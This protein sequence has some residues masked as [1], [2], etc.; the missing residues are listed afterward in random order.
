VR[1]SLARRCVRSA[2]LAAALTACGHRA[3]PFV[4]RAR[5]LS[6]AVFLVAAWGSDSL[7]LARAAEAALDSAGRAELLML[8]TSDGSGIARVNRAGGQGAQPVAPA[9]AELLVRALDLARASGG[10]FDPT[11]RDFRGLSVDTAH[12][13]VTLRRGLRLDLGAL[14]RGYALDRALLALRGA[15]DSAVLG[16]GGLYLIMTARSAERAGG[17]V[18]G[19]VDPDNTLRPLARLTVQPGIWSVSTMS[20][21][22]A[23]DA[24]LDPRTGSPAARARVVAAVA[25]SAAMAGG[26]SS[27]F[28][29]MGCDSALALAPRVGASVLCAD[30]QLRWSADLNGRVA[31][32]TDSAGSVGTAPAHGRGHAPAATAGRNGSTS[33]PPPRSS[34]SRPPTS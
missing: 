32:A 3:P 4:A 28:Y 5:E 1:G 22:E 21:A 12:H 18:V 19:I 13:T 33:L 27:A 15:A 9:L 14:G 23:R 31:P 24:V 20:L 26:W 8:P 11:G 16:S 34:R 10:A 2:L 17:R 30:G 7:R 29:V 6:G 25:P